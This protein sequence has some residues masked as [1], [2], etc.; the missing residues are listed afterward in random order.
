MTTSDDVI[1]LSLLLGS[2]GFGTIYR[3]LSNERVNRKRWIGSGVGILLVMMVSGYHTLHV[4]F[5]FSIST[6]TVLAFDVR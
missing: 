6:T 2:I 4:L 1:F 3:Q 5:A